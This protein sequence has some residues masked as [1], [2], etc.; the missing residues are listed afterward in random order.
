MAHVIWAILLMSLFCL[1]LVGVPGK[2]ISFQMLKEQW[3]SESLNLRHRTGLLSLQFTF[4][5]PNEVAKAIIIG[6]YFN[7]PVVG[8]TKSHD[9]RYRY[10]EGE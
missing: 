6:L 2:F 3:K 5:A 1:E 9:R 4:H 10:R 7:T 8:I